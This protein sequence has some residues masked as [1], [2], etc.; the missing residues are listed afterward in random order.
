MGCAMQFCIKPNR[1][2]TWGE[3]STDGWYIHASHEH[4]R[5]HEF[6]VKSTWQTRISDAVFFNHKYITQPTVAPADATV[7]LLQDLT[8]AL[9]GQQNNKGKAQMNIYQVTRIH[10][11]TNSHSAPVTSPPN[12]TNQL[13]GW[14]LTRL[15]PRWLCMTKIQWEDAQQ[16][17][18][19][20]GVQESLRLTAVSLSRRN[21]QMA[22]EAKS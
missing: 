6:F 14:D 8:H 1:R 10:H 22:Q 17:S 19:C 20:K 11:I 12:Q 16:C 21:K 3:H 18:H 7:K 2:K 5:C 9:Q 4:Y 15:V 13:Q